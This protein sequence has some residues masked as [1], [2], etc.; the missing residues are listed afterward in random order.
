MKTLYAKTDRP[1]HGPK[2]SAPTI[3]PMLEV[4]HAGTTDHFLGIRSVCF[5]IEE[6]DV[7]IHSIVIKPLY[8]SRF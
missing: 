2:S 1:K 7:E 3:P 4:A 5:G 6:N 8:K